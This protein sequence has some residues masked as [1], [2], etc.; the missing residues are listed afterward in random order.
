MH[1]D[2]A[3]GN[4][5]AFVAAVHVRKKADVTTVER[6]RRPETLLNVIWKFT[7]AH[8]TLTGNYSIK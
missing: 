8:C 2:R 5:V 7:F 3:V 4:A 1:G 6:K